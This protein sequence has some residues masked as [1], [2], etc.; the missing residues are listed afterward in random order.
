MAANQR[1]QT[2]D[3]RTDPPDLRGET[4]YDYVIV[5]AGS[6]GC[7]L[8]ARLS[9]NPDVT[10][11]LIEA[12][13]LDN[14]DE[15][16]IPAAFWTLFKSAYDWDFSSDPEPGL[17]DRRLYT[18]RAKTLGG[19]SSMNAMVYIRGN[20]ADYDGWAADGA[21]G[22]SYDE[23]LPLFKRSEDNERGEDEFH[24]A[25][26][27]LSVSDS[28]ANTPIADAVIE[29]AVKTGYERN[30]DFNGAAQEG[31]G[32]YQVTQR[33]G[34][35]C[36]TAV[37]FLRPA[38]DRPNLTVITHALALRVLF[39][40][41]RASGVEIEHGGQIEQVNADREVI[42]SAGT[43]QSPQLLMLS[44]IGPA[45]Q[46]RRLGLDVRQDLPV[47]EG[48]QDHPMFLANWLTDAESLMTALSP[49][50]IELLRTQGRGPLTSNVAEAGGFLRTRAGLDAPDVQWHCA[51]VLFYEDGLGL[52][53]DH[54]FA[55]GPCVLKPTSRGRV[56]LRT[57]KPD[58]K[59]RVVHNYLDTQE[60]RDSA[61]AGLRITMEIASHAAF[62]Q[63]TRGPF[64]V[65]DSDSD[66]DLM[67]FVRRCGQTLYHPTSTCAIG[68]VVDS[69]LRVHGVDGL[70][71][72][73]ASVMPS[74]SRGN[75]NAPTI[76]IGEKAAAL[77]REDE[78]A[79]GGW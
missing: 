7:V 20:R 48:L 36:S 73:D 56:T 13:G 23:V 4:M 51:P 70:R 29:A 60:D 57:A 55:F 77:I 6:A 22:W 31:F 58:S 74:I 59:V 24:G 38:M 8:A 34:M 49:A 46:L 21:E 44:G 41:N 26:G 18:P 76:M 28:R 75:T 11:A 66:A 16:H 54:G 61:L 37:A 9:E 33:G 67:A 45:G 1:L 10:V 3:R 12:G 64:R 53:V 50:N 63:L 25:G 27:P 17:N 62:K 47:G 71:V 52:P 14:A 68:P 5:G 32:R 69:H 79:K 19:C 15:I 72:A 2:I 39:D 42:V 78:H 35:R 43:Y 65:P 30:P 40:G